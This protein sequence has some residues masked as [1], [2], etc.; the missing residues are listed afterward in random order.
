MGGHGGGRR[1]IAA[2]PPIA[3]S[4]PMYMGQP[5]DPGASASEA[6]RLAGLQAAPSEI[7]DALRA[8]VERTLAATADSATETRDRAQTL[9]DEVVRRG[10]LARDEVARRGEEASNRLGD[11]ISDLRS[12]PAE[13]A[14]PVLDRL[15]AL[16]GR[17]TELE[18]AIYGRT[19]AQVEPEGRAG[20]PHE[21]GDS[22]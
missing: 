4:S 7:G 20:K 11:A 21:Q 17:L 22:E 6:D 15:E 16:E 10:S 1:T 3:V 8:A 12:S 9:L 13:G 14:E 2:P 19:N 5:E 18:D